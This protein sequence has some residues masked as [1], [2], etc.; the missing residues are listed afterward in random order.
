V[1]AGR[2]RASALTGDAGSA[3]TELVLITPLLL[4]FLLFVLLAGYLTDAKSDIVGASADAARA[5]SL[6]NTEGAAREQARVAAQKTVQDEG[7][8]CRGGPQVTVDFIGSFGPGAI[9]HV[10]V[11]CTINSN[12]LTFFG[13]GRS[14]TLEEEAWEQIDAHRSF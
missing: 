1:I 4:A 9:V 3:T 11:T 5:A 13:L 7:I 14:S 6:Q 8:N 12:S 2:V 10:T